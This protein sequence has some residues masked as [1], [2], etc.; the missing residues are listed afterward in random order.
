MDVSVTELRSQ[1]SDW[2]ARVRAGEE[3][4]ITERGLPVARLLG[5]NESTTALERLSEQGVIARPTQPARPAA[6]G[7]LRPRSGG[8]LVDRVSEQRQ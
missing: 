1:L 2:L 3:V 5:M 6:S 4:V 8:S 7:R